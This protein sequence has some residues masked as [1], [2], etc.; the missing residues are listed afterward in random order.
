MTSRRIPL[1]FPLLMA[2]TAVGRVQ[3]APP[4]LV[5][6]ILI[7]QLRTDYLQAFMP[8]YGNDGF[9]R[10]MEEGL[11]YSRASAAS[12]GAD[13]A[14]TAASVVTGTTPA[15]HG[16][17]GL[18]WLDRQT[19][20]PVGCVDDAS[21]N[22]V[23]T[24]EGASPRFLAVSTI[25]DELKVATEGQAMVYAVA[26]FRDVAVLT[27]GHAA[28]GALW[29]DDVTGH[30][31]T[32]DYYG[33]M[34]AWAVSLDSRHSPAAQADAVT[35]QPVSDLVGNFSYFLSGGMKKPFAHKFEGASR[36]A[37]FK[38][39]GLVN[40]E[41]T[42]M[43]RTCLERTLLGQD[44]LTDYLAVTYYA[45]NFGHRPANVAPIEL[46]D[47]YVRLD[48]AVAD[49]VEAVERR[50]GR[51]RV[52]FVITSTGSEDEETDDLHRY[53]VPSGTFDMKRAA[54]L[55]NMYFV[56]VYGQG[57]YVEG[58][59]GTQF[60]FN[61]RLIEERALNMGEMFNRAQDF[62]LRMEG[63][64]DVYTADRLLQGA[65]TPGIS[66][67]RA[68]YNPR[69]SGDVS[70]EIAP[71]WRVVNAETGENTLIRASYVPFPIIFFGYSLPAQ[72]VNTPVTVD[73]I[74]PTLSQA[75]RIRAPNACA[76]A[77]LF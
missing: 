65:W 20:R 74:A 68:A 33:T 27:A 31:C 77:P 36:Y 47:T 63:V 55:L 57:Q 54:A 15:D 41:V 37:L 58:C 59:F 43:A 22:G 52:L 50:V 3:A 75:M 9:R 8:L 23:G 25:G 10:L 39:S 71:G 45:G 34:P 21:T 5:V 2:L 40:A 19:L 73:C 30:W 16:I 56:A 70:L 53:R 51:E 4:R 35:W 42:R 64:K 61:H 60:Y 18:R 12:A 7:D 48:R 76:S 1:L 46:Q 38:T 6:N 44:A 14:A 17:V 69:Y 49:L 11:V 29:I 24:R 26:P 32:T 62:L 66:R 28:D 72:T 67:I 13:R